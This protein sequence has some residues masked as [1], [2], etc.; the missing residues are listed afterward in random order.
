MGRLSI[1][2]AVAANGVIG[3]AN[4]L[5][6]RL[7]GDLK[8]FKATT[9]G[10]HMI[11]GRRTFDS[12]GKPLPGRTTVVVTHDPAFGAPGVIVA[13]SIEEALNVA[14]ND[15]E[16]FICGGAEIYRQ[17]IHRAD[18]MYITQVHADVEGD[19][20]FPEFDDVNEW[21]LVDREDFEA[22]EKN[23]YNY[24]FLTYDRAAPAAHPIA[25][26]G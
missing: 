15:D 7:S 22:D 16:P 24:S 4:G 3:R 20:Y 11:M 5:P 23:A 21:K 8:F 14:A 19:T 9:L 2:A 17:T 26:D 12:V 25:E 1:I 13:A 6:W 10:H 18:R